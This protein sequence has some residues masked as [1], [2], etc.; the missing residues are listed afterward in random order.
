MGEFEIYADL[1][2]RTAEANR[3]TIR[4]FADDQ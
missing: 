2:R 4:M 1:E 3:R